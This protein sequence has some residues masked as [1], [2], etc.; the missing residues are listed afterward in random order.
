MS[1]TKAVLDTL[2]ANNQAVVLEECIIPITIA[3]TKARVQEWDD[4]REEAGLESLSVDE[5]GNFVNIVNVDFRQSTAFVKQFE[6]G[7]IHPMMMSN[8]AS[9]VSYDGSIKTAVKEAFKTG[10][11]TLEE[12]SE[13]AT[14]ALMSKGERRPKSKIA[15]EMLAEIFEALP[16]ARL[17][18]GSLETRIGKSISKVYA[19]YSQYPAVQRAQ[20]FHTL[21]GAETYAT[22]WKPLQ[23]ESFNEKVKAEM[24][25]IRQAEAT[26]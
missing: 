16:S 17:E 25:A 8:I 5:K 20:V 4:V 10:D 3:I 24:V 18:D 13:I 14:A 12:L 1:L 7:P 9:G 21:L 23:E 6:L 19:A 26:L 22:E 11:P 2:I 15:P